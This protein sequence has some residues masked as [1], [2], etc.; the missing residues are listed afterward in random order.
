MKRKLFTVFVALFITATTAFANGV[1]IDGLYYLLDKDNLTARV[2][3]KSYDKKSYVYNK[4]WDISVANIPS[5][6]VYKNKTYQVTKI[7]GCAF[8]SCK[9]LKSVTIPNSVTTISENAFEGCNSLTSIEIPNSVTSIEN[10]A[11]E[12]CWSLTSVT[13][14]NSVASIGIS[15][16]R[17]CTGLTSVN[18]CEGVKI[19]KEFAFYGCKRL[20]SVTIPNS[21]TSIG[22]YAF[23]NCGSLTSVTIPNSV[24][25]IGSGAFD[26]CSSLESVTI[27]NS[28]TSIGEYAFNNCNSLKSV[29]INDLAA[30][31]RI[32]FSDMYSTPFSYADNLYL[33][34]E[35]V[36]DLVM[37]NN[38]KIIR[39]Y[40]FYGCSSLNSVTIGESVKNIGNYA[41]GGC[42][43]L[44]AVT[45]GNSV[46]SIG[47]SAFKNCSSLKSVTI[48]N[49][50]TNINHFAFQ[51]CYKLASITIPKS[52][53]NIGMSVFYDCRNLT[54]YTSSSAIN[55]GN[56]GKAQIVR[57][58][59]EDLLYYYPFSIFAQKYVETG[60][61]EW[62][63]KGEF[64]RVADWQ[65]RVNETSRQQ[66][67]NKLLAEAQNKYC[68]YH[69]K[70]VKP[71]ISLGKYD[72]E[73]EVFAMTDAK[74]GTMYIAVPLSEAQYFKANWDAKK[75][76]PQAQI[77]DDEV[78][79]SA[80]T[81]SMPNGKKYTYRN[82]D[83]VTY[84]LA[85]V[86]YNFD[87][88]EFDLP[89]SSAYHLC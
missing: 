80:L 76:T 26:G 52:V 35:L 77:Y 78:K 43:N 66:K 56:A 84:N 49:S 58:S 5:T 25:S 40:A 57:L 20:V 54:I 88:I 74:Y 13:I 28:V 59:E 6:V 30:W 83:A 69:T 9:N 73:N 19:I 61:N 60:I 14:P 37:P 81:I 65:K 45:I 15:A 46:T 21:V 34:G 24:T 33:N 31:C 8:V 22:E 38:V 72:S 1:C 48:G 50:V 17:E 71:N 53:I 68:A 36:T 44:T 11:F 10:W 55:S 16:F 32:S 86:A 7:G 27:G 75:I 82:T 23:G 70:N 62:Q 47:E 39:E 2:T 85:D 67:I 12:Y 18:I 42:N 4:N 63:K 3:Y 51:Y 79:I 41:F 87:P 89:K 29:Y 64:E